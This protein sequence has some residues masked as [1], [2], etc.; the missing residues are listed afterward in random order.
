MLNSWDAAMR[1]AACSL[2]VN[3][4][5]AVALCAAVLKLVNQHERV[6]LTPPHLDKAVAVEWNSADADYLKSFG[7]YFALLTGNVTP[8]NVTFVADSLA[9]Y[10]DSAI[11]PQVRK[12][13]LA[14]AEDPAFVRSGTAIRFDATHVV[15]E[16]ASSKVFVAGEM[17]ALDAVG[18][19]EATARVYELKVTMREGR[20][21]VLAMTNYPGTEPRTLEWLQNHPDQADDGS[22][23]VA[24]E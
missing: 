17:T 20:P 8:K 6:I 15:Y 21:Y 24:K 5:L 16:P 7:T 3:L 23:S 10:V 18:R 19:R 13:I 4:L 12:S 22:Q 1:V 2:A 9:G 11:Y 14:L